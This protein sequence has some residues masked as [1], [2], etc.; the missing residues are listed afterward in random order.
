MSRLDVVVDGF[1]L[2]SMSLVLLCM[3]EEHRMQLLDVVLS[4]CDRVEAFVNHRQ[5]IG[6]TLHLGFVASPERVDAQTLKHLRNFSIAQ[7]SALDAGR[8]PCRLDCRNATQLFQP[9]SVQLFHAAPVPLELVNLA[10]QASRFPY[11]DWRKLR[12]K[13]FG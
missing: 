1:V 12:E 6:V 3:P 2:A 11:L 5:E 8:A 7:L 10:E 9:V 4:Q 13:G